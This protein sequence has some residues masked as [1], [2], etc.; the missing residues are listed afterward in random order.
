MNS[1]FI[2]AN[3][4]GA[5]ARGGNV[6]I[7]VQTFVPSGGSVI[8]GGTV[9]LVF[10]PEA[11][12]FNVVQAAAPD[13]VSGRIDVNSPVTDISGSLRGLSTEVV[14]FGALAKDL[15]RVGE[16]SSFTPV[17]RGGL[18]ATAAGMIRPESIRLAGNSAASDLGNEA[19][20]RQV[21]IVRRERCEQ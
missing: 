12:N 10:R 5:G 8:V 21:S 9:P 20:P 4:A 13:G 11:A 19:G 18:R 3:T 17:G 16:S 6:A 14:S 1:G 15:C 2:Q 7:D